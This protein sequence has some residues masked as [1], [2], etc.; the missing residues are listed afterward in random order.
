M[1]APAYPLS[2]AHPDTIVRAARDDEHAA[3]VDLLIDSNREFRDLLPTR[4]FYGYIQTLRDLVGS[5]R[6]TGRE[7]IVAELNGHLLGTVSFFPDASREGWTLPKGW[8]G[9][10]ALA[11][12]PTARGRGIGRQL[13]EAAVLRAWR[14]GAPVCCLHI[15]TFHRTARRLYHSMGFVRCPDHDLDVGDVP[16]ISADARGE[17]FILEAFRLDLTA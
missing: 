16:G 2:H 6:G 4:I 1:A 5:D 11:V 3:V 13:A 14:I 9:M 17:R 12:D 15:S 10:R 8:A 7:L